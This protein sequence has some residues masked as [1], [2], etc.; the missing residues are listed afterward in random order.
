MKY[1]KIMLILITAIFLVSIASVCATDANDT[2]VA[3]ED[4]MEIDKTTDD[5]IC[6]EENT[7][8]VS[9][10]ENEILTDA[11]QTFTQLNE[12]INANNNMDIYL[13]GNYKYSG[14]DV[15]FKNGIVIERDVNIYGNGAV[16]DGNKEARIFQINGGNV[17]FYNITF[18]NGNAGDDDGGAINGNSKAINCTFKQNQAHDGGAMYGGSAVNCTFNSNSAND[19][20][21][22]ICYGDANNCYFYDNKAGSCGGAIRFGNVDNC[23][24]INNYA[25]NYGG[26]VNHGSAYNSTFINNRAGING[27][28]MCD[29]GF[30]ADNCIFINNSAKYGGAGYA[31]IASNCNFTNNSANYGGAMYEG[32]AN[33]CVFKN[34]KAKIAGDD[35]YY[36]DTSKPILIVCNFTSIFNSGDK[37]L[38][39]FTTASGMP[40]K[41]TNI[42]IR[43]Y[44]NN[45]LVG[46]YYALSGEGW[47]VELDVGSYIAVCSVENQAYEV[48][49]ANATMAISKADTKVTSAA[50]SAVYNNN[51]NLVVTLKDSQGRPISNVAI[52]INLGGVK[53]LNTDKNGQ[54]KFNIAKL[55][56]KTYTAKVTF[57][58]NS[59]YKESSANVKV[60]VKKATPKLT[61]KSKAFKRTDKTKKYA[62]TLKTN[63]NKVMKNTKVALKV[64]GKTYSTKTNSKGVATFKLTKLTKKGKFTAVVKSAGSKYYNAKTVKPKIT[65]K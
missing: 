56:P 3:S 20:G 21:G 52:S 37:L 60:T 14:G 9:S 32:T 45:A 29:G 47:V 65:V 44:K 36:S 63:Q 18:V 53:T 33:N 13:S 58:G 19:G 4:N 6:L 50:V 61:A 16:I 59:N 54:V 55:V 26:A 48:E 31:T 49:P 43:V 34:N 24:L 38:F 11:E 28:A 7:N 39:N 57:K 2:T 30:Y 62:V 41:N 46:T 10:D 40:I 17:V 1:K 23:T 5:V 64:N 51:K 12:T 22:G 42:T 27:G 25:N 8:L 15:S 35:I